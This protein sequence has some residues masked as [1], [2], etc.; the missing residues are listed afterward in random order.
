MTYIMIFERRFTMRMLDNITDFIFVEDDLSEINE[1]DV[2]FMP[3]S[4]R[5]QLPEHIA[6]LYHKGFT[7]YILPSGK[8]SSKHNAFA[9][10]NVVGTQ[11]DN[12]YE[13]EW[14]FCQ[15]V[16]L[17][18]G[19]PNE[20]I[21][22]EDASTNTYENALFSKKTLDEHNLKIHKAIIVCQAFHARRVLMT[23]SVVFPDVDFYI[24]PIDT[25]G[26]NKANWLES[27]HG[28]ERVLGEMEKCGKYF[29][30]Y[31]T[32]LLTPSSSESTMT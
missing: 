3:G 9:T 24:S 16:L 13:T 6:N 7:K 22:K 1:V 5:Y 19:V 23:Y 15:D 10:K 18:N 14:A 29:K 25:Q 17:K 8:Y 11:Y 21:L 26:I 12:T 28:I 2:I 31:I 20:V 32:D 30:Y 27:A 4:S